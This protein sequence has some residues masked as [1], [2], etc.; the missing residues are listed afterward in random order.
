M[1][2]WGGGSF[3]DERLEGRIVRLGSC[4]ALRDVKEKE[5]R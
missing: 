2:L 4:F 1:L 3:R 5:D